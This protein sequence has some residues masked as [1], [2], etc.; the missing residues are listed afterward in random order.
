MLRSLPFLSSVTEL[1]SLHGR[2]LGLR[3]AAWGVIA[4][5]TAMAFLFLLFALYL[6]LAD[7]VGEVSAAVIVAFLV[8]AGTAAAGAI[9]L[10]MARGAKYQAQR[11]QAP[12]L[13]AAPMAVPM[14][15][16]ATPKLLLL[17]MLAGA[18]VELLRRRR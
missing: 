3:A 15:G 8:L 11:A 6:W 4:G 1:A 10:L 5:G 7:E 17:A 14:I 2:A 12:L 16:K 13:M 9:L 18:G